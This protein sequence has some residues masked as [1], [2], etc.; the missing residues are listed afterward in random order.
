VSQ[1]NA[2]VILGGWLLPASL[3]GGRVLGPALLRVVEDERGGW[4]HVC[5]GLALAQERD[6]LTEIGQ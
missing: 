5:S 1:P 2:W 4:A 6:A 3:V